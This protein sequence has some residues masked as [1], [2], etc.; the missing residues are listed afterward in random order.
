MSKAQ[1]PHP[2]LLALFPSDSRSTGLSDPRETARTPRACGVAAQGPAAG[3]ARATAL[4]I[5]PHTPHPQP[6]RRDKNRSLGSW[7]D[8][9]WSAVTVLAPSCTAPPGPTSRPLRAPRPCDPAQAPAA[10]SFPPTHLPP[11]RPA[12][13]PLCGGPWPRPL[14]RAPQ[15]F[16]PHPGPWPALPPQGGS[17]SCPLRLLPFLPPLRG[18]LLLPLPAALEFLV[19]PSPRAGPALGCAKACGVRPPRAQDVA[20]GARG[21]V[22]LVGR[23]GCLQTYLG[24]FNV[25]TCAF[26]HPTVFIHR[27]IIF[28]AHTLSGAWGNFSENPGLAV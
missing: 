13:R 16:S 27:C 14:A 3:D 15:D 6:L 8:R 10:R 18:F 26:L 5:G 11:A 9:P 21:R 28:C 20:Q 17:P 22:G 2:G 19:E 7:S 24:C 12:G 1:G 25:H 23:P 4:P